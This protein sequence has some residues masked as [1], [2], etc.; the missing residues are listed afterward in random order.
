[1]DLTYAPFMLWGQVL[2]QKHVQQ[3]NDASHWRSKL[4]A[5]TYTHRMSTVSTLQV[6]SDSLSS[7]LALGQINDDNRNLGVMFQSIRHRISVVGLSWSIAPGHI[8][9]W[10]YALYSREQLH[11][12]CTVQ[13]ILTQRL[14]ASSECSLNAY[15]LHR[16]TSYLRGS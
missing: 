7:C 6:M 5:V 8:D 10:H 1:M 13:S 12:R 4:M 14:I 9:E 3:P 16:L 2:S 15:N 11:M